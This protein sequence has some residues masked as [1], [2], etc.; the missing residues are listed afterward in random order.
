MHIKSN[1]DPIQYS[2]FPIQSISISNP[3]H[4]KSNPCHIKSRSNQIISNQIHIEHNSSLSNALKSDLIQIQSK[5][6]S[7]CNPTQLESTPYPLQSNAIQP[8]PIFIRSTTYLIKS[9]PIKS[10]FNILNT[11]QIHNQIRNI[12][13]QIH[14]QS[15]TFPIKS[16]PNANQT[17][18]DLYQL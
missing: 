10:R 14:I 1:Q 5:Y 8:N 7:R 11:S 2:S 9:T 17:I 3:T 4:I 16:L 13:N 18:S 15:N 12:S 6:R